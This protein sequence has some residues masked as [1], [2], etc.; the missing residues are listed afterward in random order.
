MT[1]GARILPVA[2]LIGVQVGI[3]CAVW[4]A[5]A[6]PPIEPVPLLGNHAENIAALPYPQAHDPYRFGAIGDTRGNQEITESLFSKLKDAEVSFVVHLGDIVPRPREAE[7][8]FLVME[9]RETQHAPILVAPGDHDVDIAGEREGQWFDR[10]LGPRQT[11]FT[12]RNDLF[13][14]A[15]NISQPTEDLV[16]WLSA[17]LQKE[18][19][20][21]RYIF[22]ALHRP[23][24]KIH[25]DQFVVDRGHPVHALAKQWGIAYVFFGD[26]HSFL[27]GEIDG[28]KYMVTGGGGSIL[29]GKS[30]FYHGTVL[31]VSDAGIQ[32]RLHVSHYATSLADAFQWVAIHVYTLEDLFEWWAIR[33]LLP[34]GGGHPYVTWIVLAA[35]QASIIGCGI[36]TARR[37]SQRRRAV[38]R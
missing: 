3:L 26:Y 28:V 25:K 10:V 23:I 17:V 6:A 12:F 18:A 5:V 13:L 31:D 20:G 36:W 9:F 15:D 35:L 30:G 22:L 27:L 8:R 14:I 29:Y 33:Y 2:L 7:Y 21:R 32:W 38:D 1:R 34:W 19:K 24:F 4:I 37:G 11:Y 16:R